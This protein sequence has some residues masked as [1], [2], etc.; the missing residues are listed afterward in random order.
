MNGSADTKIVARSAVHGSAHLPCIDLRI[1][2]RSRGSP[3]GGGPR[4]VSRMGMCF[5]LGRRM[6]ALHRFSARLLSLVVLLASGCQGSAGA[7]IDASD[8]DAPVDALPVDA[9]SLDAD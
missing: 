8:G 7:G 6:N 2:G 4:R 1:E 3:R 9:L 5:A